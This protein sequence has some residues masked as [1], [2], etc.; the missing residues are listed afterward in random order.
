MNGR[1]FDLYVLSRDSDSRT[2]VYETC[3]GD[4][5]FDYLTMEFLDAGGGVEST[6]VL[7][8]INPRVCDDSCFSRLGSLD[9]APFEDEFFGDEDDIKEII[10]LFNSAGLNHLLTLAYLVNGVE[11]LLLEATD[12]LTETREVISCIEIDER[13]AEEMREEETFDVGDYI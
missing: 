9:E 6:S 13:I 1:F 12:N 10:T 4:A 5:H 11:V 7:G 3:I 8:F 2:V